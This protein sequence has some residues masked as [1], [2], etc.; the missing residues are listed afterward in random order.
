MRVLVDNLEVLAA[1]KARENGV[2]KGNEKRK[3]KRDEESEEKED[4]QG[5][6]SDT[7]NKCV[8]CN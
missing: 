2:I 7:D 3:R 6:S 4:H 8:F 5:C 1:I